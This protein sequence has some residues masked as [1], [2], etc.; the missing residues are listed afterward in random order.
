[1]NDILWEPRVMKYED[2]LSLLQKEHGEAFTLHME[3]FKDQ[4]LQ[5]TDR[6]THVRCSRC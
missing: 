6:Y 2:M 5:Q 1:M 4:L 3:A